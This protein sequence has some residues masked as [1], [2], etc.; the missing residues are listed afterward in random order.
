MQRYHD[1]P[2]ASDE[3]EGG[4]VFPSSSSRLPLHLAQYLGLMIFTIVVTVLVVRW[5][6]GRQRDHGRRL[7]ADTVDEPDVISLRVGLHPERR[8]RRLPGQAVTFNVGGQIMA[9]GRLQGGTTM[10]YAVTGAVYVIEN[11][12]MWA[13]GLAP[14]PST[15]L[16]A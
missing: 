3:R 9:D 13:E 8:I 16:V 6:Q 11:G 10:V 2:R 12:Q 7:D 4:K 15:H 14:T 1:P 5:C